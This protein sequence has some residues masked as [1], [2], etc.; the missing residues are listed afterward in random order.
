[1]TAG[2]AHSSA[3]TRF[4]PRPS[5]IEHTNDGFACAGF[6]QELRVH[7]RARIG[8]YIFAVSFALATLVCMLDFVRCRSIDVEQME[9]EMRSGGQYQSTS[10]DG[11]S[12]D[13]EEASAAH[14]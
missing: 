6:Q 12:G 10:Q 14:I 2:K 7:Q 3:R 13:D 1:M 8:S 11:P 5:A 9:R 4:A